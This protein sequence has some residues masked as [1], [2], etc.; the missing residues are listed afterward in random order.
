MGHILKQTPIEIR[1]N[2]FHP[3]PQTL[4]LRNTLDVVIMFAIKADMLDGLDATPFCG[5]V[6][7]S[8]SENIELSL[9][10]G[11]CACNLSVDV[12][13][14]SDSAPQPTRF[15]R[16]LFFARTPISFPVRVHVE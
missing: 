5:I 2:G 3:Y 10:V 16:D 8:K 15:S 9:P 12:V 13:P 11:P 1:A 4:R 14:L 6:E 7:P